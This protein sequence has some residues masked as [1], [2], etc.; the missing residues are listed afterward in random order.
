M[1]YMNIIHKD[2]ITECAFCKKIKL[3]EY[4]QV[5]SLIFGINFNISQHGT[6]TECVEGYFCESCRKKSP[7]EIV[8]KLGRV[9]AADRYGPNS[10]KRR[11]KCELVSNLSA[12]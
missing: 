8:G 3:C 1:A 10:W 7:G 4:D 9:C 12:L 6:I 11:D 2:K 5:K